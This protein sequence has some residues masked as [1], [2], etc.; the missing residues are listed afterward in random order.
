MAFKMGRARHLRASSI[1]AGDVHHPIGMQLLRAFLECLD[2]RHKRAI[3]R[4]DVTAATES[5]SAHDG[6][7]ANG[8]NGLGT[9]LSAEKE[10]YR[11]IGFF[12][13]IVRLQRATMPIT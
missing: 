10:F 1:G 6:F 13:H 2:D 12:R 8:F 3:T 11:A 4:D 9:F 7:V 5:F